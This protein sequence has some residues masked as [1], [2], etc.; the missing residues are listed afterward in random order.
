MDDEERAAFVGAVLAL[1]NACLQV[2]DQ[3]SIELSR[4]TG[5]GAAR[6]DDIL[7]LALLGQYA[8]DQIQD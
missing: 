1:C 8:T 5:R 3:L 2:C 6:A 7:R 4:V